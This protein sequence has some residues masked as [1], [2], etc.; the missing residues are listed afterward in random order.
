MMDESSGNGAFKSQNKNTKKCKL[1][2][3]F[4][5]GLPPVRDTVPYHNQNDRPSI[6][7]QSQNDSLL[8]TIKK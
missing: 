5:L 3:E 8:I 6:A 7:D 4:M 1:K 2:L